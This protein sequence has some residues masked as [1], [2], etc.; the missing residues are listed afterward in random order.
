MMF[1]SGTVF[2]PLIP[3]DIADVLSMKWLTFLPFLDDS[4]GATSKLGLRVGQLL[5]TRQKLL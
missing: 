5:F 3:L 4:Q 2:P 1:L